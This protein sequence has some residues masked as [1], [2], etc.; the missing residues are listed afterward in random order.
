MNEENFDFE[1]YLA[2]IR[3]AG[4][5]RRYRQAT[6]VFVLLFWVL[7]V[8]G[9]TWALSGCSMRNEEIIVEVNRCRDNG[10]EARLVERIQTVVD[11]QCVVPK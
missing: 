1:K 3:E 8:V 5:A 2:E 10:L 9:G 11:V 7:A 4:R 6:A